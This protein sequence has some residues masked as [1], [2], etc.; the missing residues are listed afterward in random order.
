MA[1]DQQD[2]DRRRTAPAGPRSCRRRASIVASMPAASWPGSSGRKSS[3]TWRVSGRSSRTQ[4]VERDHQRSSGHTVDD[5]RAEH[6]QTEEKALASRSGRGP[7]ERPPRERGRA[8]RRRTRRAPNAD[9]VGQPSGRRQPPRG[10]RRGSSLR[11]RRRQPRPD[12]AAP[13]PSRSPRAT[14]SAG[15]SGFRCSATARRVP[16][17]TAARRARSAAIRRAGTA[18]PPRRRSPPAAVSPLPRR[19]LLRALRCT[20]R[21]VVL[22]GRHGVGLKGGSPRPPRARRCRLWQAVWPA[23][24]GWPG[25][26][27]RRCWR[28]L[29]LPPARRRRGAS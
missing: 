8:G 18:T 16:V 2:G 6:D 13:S 26:E 23:W 4:V 24:R 15:R 28:S 12:R 5:E 27:G 22:N 10:R 21:P 14:R 7:C 1:E 9:E 20:C 11:R 17:P 3:R 19:A 25:A 29:R